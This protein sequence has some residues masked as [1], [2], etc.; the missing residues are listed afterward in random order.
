MNYE[1]NKML[2]GKEMLS[3]KPNIRVK[4]KKKEKVFQ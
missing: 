1:F 2:N 3:Q 4:L